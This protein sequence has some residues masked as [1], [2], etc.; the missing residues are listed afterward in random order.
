MRW[1][2]GGVVSAAQIA[3]GLSVV[4]AL[5]YGGLFGLFEWLEE[6]VDAAGF[7]CRSDYSRG[8]VPPGEVPP[9]L[10]RIVRPE[11]T[12]TAP[13]GSKVLGRG[14]FEYF[15]LQKK[16]FDESGY[17]SISYFVSDRPDPRSQKIASLSVDPDRITFYIDEGNSQPTRW[18]LNRKTL[19]MIVHQYP[20]W[21]RFFGTGD[22]WSE[23]GT[24]PEPALVSDVGGPWLA[25]SPENLDVFSCASVDP[26]VLRHI[27]RQRYESRL[28]GNKI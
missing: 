9:E 5:F 27:S 14:G 16:R 8:P 7:E 2:I 22:R 3:F 1:M 15:V 17:S 20:G 26:S 12:I 23:L 19:S 21:I 13:D 4:I 24:T 11:K 18:V 10:Q 25:H 28:V 6:E